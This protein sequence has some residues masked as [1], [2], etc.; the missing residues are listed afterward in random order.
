MPFV[1]YMVMTTRIKYLSQ[2]PSSQNV[3]VGTRVKGVK[4]CFVLAIHGWSEVKP[5]ESD[6]VIYE[7]PPIIIQ[8]HSLY[9]SSNHSSYDI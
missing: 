3:K 7:K 9:R 6:A 4:Y 2:L 8:N 1:N 5:A